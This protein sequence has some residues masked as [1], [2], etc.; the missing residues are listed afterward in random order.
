MSEDTFVRN[1]EFERGLRHKEGQEF[2]SEMQTESM[3]SSRASTDSGSPPCEEPFA[4]FRAYP[5]LAARLPR[6]PLAT[7]PTPIEKLERIG[8]DLGV[9]DLYIKRDDLSGEIYGGNKVRKLEFLFGDI[10]NTRAKSVMTFGFAGSNHALATAIY[11]KQLGLKSTSLLMPQVN[12]HYVRCNL[13]A[14]HHYQARLCH[15]RNC[16]FVFLGGIGKLL[17]G[18]LK[19][20]DFPRIIPGGGSCPRGIVGYVNAAMELKDQI[21]AGKLP[22]PDL[23]YVPLGSMGTSVG[24]ILGLRAA[25]LNKTRV[26]PVR[27]IEEKMASR[28]RFLKLFRQTASLLSKGDPS[29][30]HL[31]LK[32]D[33]L[34]IRN[35]CMGEGY[36]HFTRK[37]VDAADLMQRETGIVLNGAYSAKA[38]SAL[39]DDARKGALKGK[40]VVFWNTYNSRDL[41][42][43]ASG[44]DYHALPRDFHRY[45]EMAVQPLDM[46]DMLGLNEANRNHR[47]T[48]INASPAESTVSS[49]P[50][51]PRLPSLAR[52]TVVVSNCPSY[53]PD[54]VEA[55]LKEA[56]EALGGLSA[57]V[58]PGQTVLVKPN[59]FTAHPPEHAVTT[60]PELV[61]HVV[62]LC[63]KAGAGRIWVG[64]SPVGSQDEKELW[65]R[66]G[67]VTAVADT[68]A[69]LKSWHAKQS[70]LRCGEDV[71]AVPEWYRDV[72]VVISLPK[73]KAHCLTTITC[74][75]KNVYGI[76]S[77]QAKIQF[78]MKYPSPLTMSAFL[79]G[80]FAEL[81]PHLTI[82]DAVVAM[83]GNGPAHGRPVQVGALLASRDTVA[84]DAV[85]CRALK[86]DPSDVPMIRLASESNLGCMDESQIECIGSG[87]S[88]LRE[89]HMK[90]SLSRF[91][92]WVPEPLFRLS[93]ILWQLRPKI[94]AKHCIQCGN[95]ASTC[96]KRTIKEDVRT[97]Y[98]RIGQKD[99]IA[100]FCCVE[101]CPQGAIALQLYLGSWICVARKKGKKVQL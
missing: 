10:L 45:F 92:R 35:D 33:E 25:G 101:S 84:L 24:L 74:G 58:Q 55:A 8:A 19:G 30:P 63:A 93:T 49:E 91:L 98:P 40:T 89:T 52:S 77:G 94:I 44:V 99:C 42:E 73:L 3:N 22:E 41:S 13:L 81:K 1:G 51:K 37:G 64:D 66:T 68:P 23:I 6:V 86:I 76:V 39:L 83:E 59:L 34:L 90:S 38:F 50:T 87:I 100:C 88:R 96:P 62:L 82:A 60:H 7:L 11:A 69:E 9:S 17:R 20:G 21:A 2:N 53:S 95:C 28:K 29:F 18:W 16:L 72:D 12:A 61:R 97:G 36:A 67:M 15:Y 56:V 43:V 65:S 85:G 26:V 5:R 57:F 75:L 48:A 78:H 46:K 71:L 54:A 32:D 27:V 14:S 4:L 79:V 31:T 70:P 80:V 47:R